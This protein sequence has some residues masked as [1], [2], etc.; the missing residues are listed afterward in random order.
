[1]RTRRVEIEKLQEEAREKQLA[2]EE[3]AGKEA[4]AKEGMLIGSSRPKNQK[5]STKSTKSTSS[6]PGTETPSI[7]DDSR[8]LSGHALLVYNSLK[9][10]LTTNPNQEDGGKTKSN[11]SSSSSDPSFSSWAERLGRLE[12][13]FDAEYDY[14]M[15][16]PD[17]YL[18]ESFTPLYADGEIGSTVTENNTDSGC[19]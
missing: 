6:K 11:S 9:S 7:S 19:G 15:A 12:D 2:E 4:G 17:Q 8:H 5:N 18:A 16:N 1:M 3:K 14:Y 13:D 10:I